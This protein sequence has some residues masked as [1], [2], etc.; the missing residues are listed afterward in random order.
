MYLVPGH[1][2]LVP[3]GVPGPGGVPDPRGCTWSWEGVPGLEWYL[4]W[5]VYLVG[6]LYL[7]RGLYL[8]SGEVPG[9]G[10]GGVPGPRGGVP[11]Q[12]LPPVNR[13]SDRHV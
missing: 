7:V 5:G 2:P 3:E 12:V 6:G 11:G 9:L 1:V 13:M 10:G 4:V 8:V